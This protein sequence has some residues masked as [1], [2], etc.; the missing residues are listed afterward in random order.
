MNEID[1]PVPG[2]AVSEPSSVLNALQNGLVV[3]CQPVDEGPMDEPAIVAA[4]ARAAVAGGA[5]GLRIEGV[6]N[7]RAVRPLV[8]VPIIGIVKTTT[9][10]TPVRITVS[11]ENVRD[12]I[13]AG[14]DIIAYDATD[15]PRPDS[16]LLVA[17]AIVDSGAT[18]M[19]DCSSSSDATR[20]IEMGAQII[21]TTLSGY[22]NDT[23]TGDSGPDLSLIRD[24][25][26]LGVF[27]MAEGRISTPE[28][29]RRALASGANS[30][31]VGTSLTRLEIMTRRFAKAVGGTNFRK[32]ISGYALDL[33]GT[34][35]AAIRI[36]DGIVVDRF[37]RATDSKN[38]PAQQVS[39]MVEA[40]AGLGF[41]G[42]EPLGVAVTGR[43]DRAGRWSAVNQNTLGNIRQIP[44]HSEL[45]ARFAKVSV[46]NDAAAATLAEQRLGVGRGIGDFAF[47]TVSTGVA[48]GLVLG[49]NLVL[50]DDGLAG[51]M[52][53][54]TT[55]LGTA[56]CGSG[57][58]GT[59]ESVASGKAIAAEA[60]A[61]GYDMDASD[62]FDQARLGEPWAQEIFDRSA[63][64]IAEMIGNLAAIL[65]IR[66]CAIGGSVGL[67][68]GYIDRVRHHIARTPGLFAVDLA[69]AELGKDGPLIGALIAALEEE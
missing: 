42:H 68:D 7:L 67:S 29:A 10:D 39:T 30:V 49:G 64:A 53:F 26:K 65:G 17:Q 31:T 13:A 25:A 35:T 21:G 63:S 33:G 50:S 14:A 27:V 57:R 44:L 52:G 55:Q 12:L 15:R 8:D 60:R 37:H 43:V 36:S 59:V 6:E 40:L 11:L 9:E 32:S 4:M 66:S 2:S 5:A 1:K 51:H 28:D 62:V 61:A 45:S 16:T 20:A 34:K 3:S 38:S 46:L 41:E 54:S 56:D 19:A 58:F 24:F 69:P 47:V 18:A 23:T 22:T 48:G